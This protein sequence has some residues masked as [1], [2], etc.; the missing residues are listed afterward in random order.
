MGIN[1]Y[2]GEVTN[3]CDEYAFTFSQSLLFLVSLYR[4]LNTA[5]VLIYGSVTGSYNKKKKK[6]LN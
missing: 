3:G 1:K 4:L 6:N 2:R 5:L